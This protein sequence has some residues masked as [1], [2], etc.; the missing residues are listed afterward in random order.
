[1]KTGCPHCKAKFTAR[2]ENVGKKAK[3]P[4]CG[5]LFTISALEETPI[6]ASVQSKESAKKKD[7]ICSECEAII[8]P[9]QQACVYKG[10]I[11]CERCYNK[12]IDTGKRPTS[13]EASVEKKVESKKSLKTL[14][15]YFWAATRIIAGIVCA[16][17]LLSAI[18]RGADSALIATFA[19]G[20]VLL[21]G[22]VLIE[23]AMI[24]KMW[25]AIQ[26]G[27]A[28]VSAAKAVGFLFVPVFNIYWAL[29]M[30]V[31][32]AEDYN[33]FVDRHKVKTKD[34]PLVLFLIY[35]FMFLLSS[36]AVTIP[37][38]CIFAFPGLLK[39]AVISRP[40]ISWFLFF[41]ILA[42]GVGHFI[43]Y[44]MFAM[45][46]CNAIKALPGTSAEGALGGSK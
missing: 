3:C 32:F 28:S 42:L 38:I 12:M 13:A 34:L 44:L 20:D 25:T 2:E 45:K 7:E 31:G 29:Y 11:V 40:Q 46:T 37:M 36:I 15:V 4:K 24:Y 41:F 17:G 1:M 22:S 27:R 8:G 30:F 14:Y 10:N 26:D 21:I 6:E 5:Q 33:S 16:L 18:K 43:I 23:L 9:E 39:R 19:A 35:A